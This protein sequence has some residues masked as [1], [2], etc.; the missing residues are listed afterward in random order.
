MPPHPHDARAKIVTLT[1]RGWACT[2]A[3]DAAAARFTEQWA[4]TLGGAATNGLR[5]ALARV[6][7]PGR[8]RPSAW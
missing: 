1:E 4:N 8:V 2:R 7:T 6:V 5:D 3:A